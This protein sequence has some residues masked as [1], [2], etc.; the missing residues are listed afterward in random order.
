M[1]KEK[2]ISVDVKIADQINE[3]KTFTSGV[4]LKEIIDSFQ[5]EN[6]NDYV[7]AFLN[8]TLKELNWKV[9]KDAEVEFLSKTSVIGFDLYKRS[10]VLLMLKA[11][12]DVLC[13]SE[14]SYR[15][16]VM[17]SLANGFFCR[18]V[19]AETEVTEE[20]L[21]KIKNR[22][23]ELVEKDIPIG[24]R[25]AYTPDMRRRFLERD[26]PGKAALLKYRRASR[27]NVYYLDDYEDYYY[28][29]MVPSTGCL[30]L[31]DLVKY[32]DGFV[33]VIP[34]RKTFSMDDPYKAPDKLY[35][36]LRQSEDWGNKLNIS[37]VGA[38]NDL[39]VSGWGNHLILMQEAL[40]EK[41]I[42]N[43]AETI[44]KEDRRI[45]LI[46]GPSSSGKTTFSNRLSVQLGTFGMTPYPIAMDN[47]FKE[48]EDTP[49]DADG[50]YDFECIEAMD[51]KL[52]NDTMSGLLEGREMPMPTF[53]FMIGK[54]VYDGKTIKLNK[55]DVLVVEGIH[56]LNPLSTESLPKDSSFKIYISALT[57]LNIDEHNRISTTDTRLLRRIVRDART[58]GNSA[59]KT[60]SMWQ[61]VRRGEEQNIFPFQ[62]E[63][64]AMFN[65]AM[66]YE[67]S[68]IKQFAEPLLFGVPEDSDEYYEAKRLLKFLDY[69]LGIDISLIPQNSL[70]REFI[71]GGCF[72]V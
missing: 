31:F 33:L 19:D 63:A 2:Q 8:K 29:Y 56:A 65:S 50:K 14:G 52:F 5:I 53:D 44:V 10:V 66:I 24:K 16:E 34:D 12:K 23:K 3:K 51:L 30:T 21:E 54:K 38:L 22:M 45:I 11:A 49:K 1:G 71:G 6:K 17:Y 42:A 35:N 60:I 37:C 64:D 15:I 62:E 57:Q 41:Q 26:L 68:A 13:K 43:I 7:A 27:T 67:L 72:K 59:T 47:F 46:A 32:D 70:M 55:G 9:Y 48:R 25:I 69:F 20:L 58:R 4:T 36:V 18:L 40:M 61:S 39:I 28:G